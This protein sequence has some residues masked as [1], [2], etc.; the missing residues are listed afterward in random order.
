MEE[1]GVTGA[2]R[3]LC[4]SRGSDLWPL[5]LNTL[6]KP[7]L[8][9]VDMSENAHVCVW[10]L[11]GVKHTVPYAWF[12]MSLFSYRT[13]QYSTVQMWVCVYVTRLKHIL[14]LQ[15]Q[16]V[17]N[18]YITLLYIRAVNLKIR[19]TDRPAGGCT[20]PEDH[21]PY[22]PSVLGDIL[23]SP[24]SNPL[25]A[26]HTPTGSPT[27]PRPL[28]SVIHALLGMWACGRKKW[29]RFVISFSFFSFVVCHSRFKKR[30]D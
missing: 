25:P 24:G 16:V 21:D 13:A 28:T 19:Q 29:G 23:Y 7:S 9:C 27:P 15:N 4:I 6:A 2:P 20:T 17:H 30:W 10:L 5:S 1:M 3:A 12:W 14:C 26:F 8:L 18:M 11:P 22:H